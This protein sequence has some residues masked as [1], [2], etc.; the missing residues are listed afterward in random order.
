[1][2]EDLNGINKDDCILIFHVNIRY[3]LFYLMAMLVIQI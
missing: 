1:M 3:W 2:N